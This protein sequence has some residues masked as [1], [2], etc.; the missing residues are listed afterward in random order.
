MM[1]GILG[2]RRW[3]IGVC[4]ALSVPLI[5]AA[6]SN[7]PAERFTANAINMSEIGTP[8]ATPI[9]ITI[10]RWSSDAERERL[11]STLMDKGPDALLKALQKTPKVGYIRTPTSLGY[12]LHFAWQER[13][14]EG[15]RRIVIATDRP[16]GFREA[17]NQPRTIHYPFTVIELHMKAEGAGEGKLSIATRIS[18]NPRTKTIELE[19]YATQPVMLT[20][21]R[22]SRAN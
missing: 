15:G 19:N 6:Q 2:S 14:D 9:E 22:S 12:D 3:L 8:G 21:V 13:T 4:L 20:E 1:R 16:I 10:D 17:V 18:G 5:G 11:V 7:A